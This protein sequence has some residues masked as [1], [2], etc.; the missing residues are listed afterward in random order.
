[1]FLI[2]KTGGGP[3]GTEY[4]LLK[5]AG[6]LLGYGHSGETLAKISL[7]IK[8]IPKTEEHKANISLAVKGIGKG[9]PKTEEHKAKISAANKSVNHFLYNKNHMESAKL[10]ISIAKGTIVYV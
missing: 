9:I 5:K 3:P 4:N 10:I 2:L 7:A 1:M 8:G 6:S